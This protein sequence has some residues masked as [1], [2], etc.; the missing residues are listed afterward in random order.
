M[1]K[2]DY[3][4]IASKIK[5]QLDLRCRVAYPKSNEGELIKNDAYFPLTAL[6]EHMANA[7]K[8]DN[9]KFDRDKFLQACGIED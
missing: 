9:P 1:T 6:A 7:L 3:E 4:L 5:Q 2:K 8:N